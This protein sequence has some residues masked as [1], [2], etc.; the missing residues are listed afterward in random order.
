MGELLGIEQKI[1]HFE[2]IHDRLDATQTQLQGDKAQ[3]TK[4]KHSFEEYLA[5]A[6]DDIKML[7]KTVKRTLEDIARINTELL[8]LSKKIDE[9]DEIILENKKQIRTY[10]TLSYQQNGTL[11]HA[12]G[13]VDVLY[14]LVQ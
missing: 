13:N 12:D 5:E 7:E 6:D 11:F 4:K 2:R 9:I 8:E 10:I 3:V 1:G 14:A